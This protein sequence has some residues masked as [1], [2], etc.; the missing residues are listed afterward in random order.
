MWQTLIVFIGMLPHDE[1]A[2]ERLIKE[3]TPNSF[4]NVMAS[5]H[6]IIK[7]INTGTGTYH[8]TLVLTIQMSNR[9]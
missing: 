1:P 5:N 9:K 4:I 7:L 2:A 8:S 3:L 6:A